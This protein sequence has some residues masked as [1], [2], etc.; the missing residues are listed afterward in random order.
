MKFDQAYLRAPGSKLESHIQNQIMAVNQ[1][2]FNWS[3]AMTQA[4]FALAHSQYDCMI[5]DHQLLAFISSHLIAGEAEIIHV[6]VDPA[7]R[8]QG[9]GYYLL[10]QLQKQASIH[11]LFLEVR[12]SNNP[13]INLYQQANFT[14]LGRRKNYYQ[15]PI[16]DALVMNWERSDKDDPHISH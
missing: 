7:W 16:E 13:A 12:A 5:D 10:K 4:D 11:H 14:S 8:G 3:P 1:A 2:E 15:D 9:L 6:W